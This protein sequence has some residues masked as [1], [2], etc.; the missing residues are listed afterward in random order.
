MVARAAAMVFLMIGS[1]NGMA[2]ENKL[3]PRTSWVNFESF[4]YSGTD[5]AATLLKSPQQ[6]ADGKP[7][8]FFYRVGD[9]EFK[10]LKQNVDGSVLSTDTAGGFQGV[11]QGMFA[12]SRK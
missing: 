5:D 8:S 7:Y 9:A 2:A 10:P 12:R 11:M 4:N 3:D 6:Q 1:V